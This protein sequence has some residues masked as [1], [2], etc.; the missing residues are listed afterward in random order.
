MVRTKKG[1]LSRSTSVPRLG[2]GGLSQKERREKSLKCESYRQLSQETGRRGV[3]YVY[4]FEPILEKNSAIASGATPIGS[5]VAHPIERSRQTKGEKLKP[6]IKNQL[7]DKYFRRNRL[8]FVSN[9]LRL[10]CRQNKHRLLPSGDIYESCK[11]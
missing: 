8:H 11:G 2:L 7:V 4:I 1:Y 9:E 6:M 3:V 10:H 5:A